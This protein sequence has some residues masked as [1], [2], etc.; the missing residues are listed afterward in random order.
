[1]GSNTA[2]ILLIAFGLLAL[3]LLVGFIAFAVTRRIGGVYKDDAPFGVIQA[4]AFALVGLLLGFSFSLA[5]ARYDQRRSV[6]V[7]EANAIGTTALRAQFLDPSLAGPMLNALRSYVQAR[8][9]FAAATAPGARDEPSRRSAM[10]Q[11]QMW[12]MA[13]RAA[14]HD[15]Y[16]VEDMLFVQ[17][18]N[19]TI[20]L[21][22]EQAA[23]LN[24]TIPGSVLAIVIAVML[25]AAALLG[26]NYGRSGRLGVAAYSVFAAML[27]LTVATIIDLDRPQSGFIRVPLDSLV[28]TQQLVESLKP[29]PLLTR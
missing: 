16:S 8:I 10:L 19:N 3:T 28:Q 27:A 4:S 1:M 25:L 29:V 11:T 22:S 18:L 21:S 13:V 26:A 6:T 2:G 17:T 23:A 14:R 12:A 5:V 7:R 20:D 9:D 15:P 24:G